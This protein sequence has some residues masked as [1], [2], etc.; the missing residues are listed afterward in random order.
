MYCILL[1]PL[2]S[3]LW[4]LCG[5]LIILIIIPYIC[6]ACNMNSSQEMFNVLTHYIPQK[7]TRRDGQNRNFYP[8]FKDGK[9]EA[10]PG[11]EC[12][13]LHQLADNSLIKYWRSLDGDHDLS[14]HCKKSLQKHFSPFIPPSYL[15]AKMF[16]VIGRDHLSLSCDFFSRKDEKHRIRLGIFDCLA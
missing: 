13:T 3:V 1:I 10:Q 5:S 16:T 2:F 7:P 14:Y 9:T 4:H 12:E 11:P 15:N 8:P 6:R